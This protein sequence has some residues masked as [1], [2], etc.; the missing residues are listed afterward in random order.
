MQSGN[1]SASCGG[2]GKFLSYVWCRLQIAKVLLEP[3][4]NLSAAFFGAESVNLSAAF[5]AVAEFV[6]YFGCSQF[7]CQLHLV[8][9]VNLSATLGAVSKYVGCVWCS[10]SIYQVRVVPSVSLSA[11][12]GL[13]S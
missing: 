12:L 5:W 13:A 10:Q 7:I 6:C 3:S 1:V 4:V 11:T 9:S 8:Q 2:V